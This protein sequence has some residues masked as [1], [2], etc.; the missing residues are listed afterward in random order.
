[1]TPL[2]RL[3]S[4]YT[5]GVNSIA[6]IFPKTTWRPWAY[7]VSFNIN[8]GPETYPVFQKA[9]DEAKIAF[10]GPRMRVEPQGEHVYR[11]PIKMYTT[12]DKAVRLA[13]WSW[14]PDV[15]ICQFGSVVYMVLQIACYLGF[16]PIYLLGID[17]TR[18]TE[19]FCDD[20]WAGP[21]PSPDKIDD[22]KRRAEAAF[23]V[24]RQMTE[25]RGIH[26]YDATI[27][28]GLQVFPKVRLED[29]L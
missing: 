25:K 15:T 6:Q 21:Q 9:I 7:V 23:G 1:M 26:I 5:F 4:E 18:P 19:H 29:I 22:H 16:N 8:R 14:A 12:P 2:E 10:I 17:H 24:A 28:G 20:Y 3:T 11:V 27:G 13:F